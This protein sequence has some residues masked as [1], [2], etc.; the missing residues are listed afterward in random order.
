MFNDQ[1]LINHIKTTNTLQIESFILGEWNLNDFEN[2]LKYGNYRYRLSSSS[3]YSTLPNTYDEL[4]AGDYYTDALLSNIVTES[5]VDNIDEPIQVSTLE[6]NRDLYF[7]L[8]ECFQP[9]RPRSGI[10]KC[11]WFDNKYIDNIKSARR[12]RYYLSSRY[13]KFKYWNSYRKEDSQQFGIS[14]PTTNTDRGYSIEDAAPFIVYK[15]AVAANRIV[16]KM[17]TNLSELSGQQVRDNDGTVILDPLT[18]I[19]KSSIPKIWKVQ[20]LSNNDNWID[21]IA[22]DENSV[23][24][25]GSSIVNWDGHVELFYDIVVPEEYKD[26]FNFVSSVSASSQLPSP[27]ISGESYLVGGNTSN[28]GELYI[29]NNDKAEWDIS[30]PQ[31]GFSLLEDDDTKRLGIVSK[32]TDAEYFESNGIRTYRDVAYLK[33]LRVVVETM[34]SPNTTFDLIELSPRLKGNLSDY[35]LTYEINKKISKTST[36]MP[37]GG[38]SA[39]DGQ[40][41]LMNFD[42]SFNENNTNSLIYNQ[43]KPNVKIEF[44]EIVLNVEGYDKFIPIK[45]MYTEDFPIAVGGIFEVNIGLRDL[46]FKLETMNAPEILLNNT[47]LT[48]AVS[49]LLDNIGFSNYVFKNLT[50]DNDTIIPYFFIEPDTSVAEVLD[51]LAVATQTAMFFDEYNNFVVMSKEYLMPENYE[52]VEDYTLY[53]EKE[54]TTFANIINLQGLE[55][56][57]INSGQ[58]NYT[59]RY[60]QRSPSSLNQASKVDEDRTYV[61]KPVLLWEIGS[62]EE[63]KTINEKSKQVGYALG[64]VALNSTL[65]SEIPSVVNHKIINNIIDIGENVYWLPRFQGYLYA[66]GEVI[67]YDAVQYVIS[68]EAVPKEIGKYRQII[69]ENTITIV[70]I[71]KNN[72]TV[73]E[74]SGE[75]SKTLAL[76]KLRTLFDNSSTTTNSRDAVKNLV[77][78]TNNQEYQKYFANLPF[79]GKM[80]PTGSVRIY[81]EP[82]YEEVQ[83]SYA[84]GLEPNVILKNGP[85][86]SNGRGQFNTR[87]VQHSAGLSSYWSDNNNVRGLSMAS[88]YLFTTTPTERISFP[89][90]SNSSPTNQLPQTVPQQSLRTGI[91]ANFMRQNISVEDINKNFQTTS[92]GTIQ[93]SA[94]VFSGPNPLPAGSSNRDIVSYVYKELDKDYKHFGTRMRIIGKAESSEKILTA[95]NAFTYYSVDPQGQGDSPNISGGSGGIS[96]MVNPNTHEGYY[97]EI[98][99]LTGDNLQRYSLANEETGQATS[100]L[101]NIVFYKVQPGTVNNEVV[102]VPYKLWGGLAQIIVDEGKFVGQDRVSNQNN[103]T[104]Y[105]L[106][107]EYEDIG[108]IRRFYLY[109]N[110]SQVATVEDTSPLPAYSNIA[111]FTRGTSKCMFENVYALKNL[112][113]QETSKNIVDL[114]SK[115]FDNSITSSEAL[116]KYSMSG[117][118]QDTYLSGINIDSDKKFDIY[119]EEFGTIMRECAYFNIKYDKAYP[120][121]IAYI[122]PTFNKEKTYTVSGFRAGAYGAEFLIFNNTDKSIVLDETSGNYLRIIG[123]T[124]TQNTSNVLTVDDY[125]KQISNFFDPNIENNTL[126]SP[127]SADKVYKDIKMSRSRYGNKEF[128]LS[129]PYIQTDDFARNMMD[130]IIKKSLQPKKIIFMET[131][132]TSHLQ[133]GDIVKIRYNLPDGDIL[134]DPNKKFV[135]SEIFYS[136]SVSDVRNRIG[137]IEV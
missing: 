92:T 19:N 5:I 8:K 33:G 59:T 99:S 10:N 137:V 97:F 130:W 53:A 18:D 25:N 110:N 72:E 69:S 17:Q 128:S 108:S 133:L 111:L 106:A 107:V 42:G 40:L 85:V 82:Y 84:V 49:V 71:T 132:G 78:I 20:Y 50:T 90:K 24:R 21:A 100:V 63:S 52:R 43:L 119:F 105:D 118:I 62:Q 32:L 135:I 30:V 80:Y 73:A 77:W 46:F 122:A 76:N 134:I 44:Y 86:K 54:G 91:I 41:S 36:N 123:I 115:I 136:R 3:I 104:I 98:V 88:Q 113:T 120:A 68:G 34:Y 51:R 124:F 23:R 75:N 83:G 87:V 38:L 22:F 121:F 11:L 56:N 4:D 6:I 112:Q 55:K 26:S 103:P 66:N 13:D 39:S 57:V 114:S 65:T 102:L 101:H 31:Y 125:F 27:L 7:S 74:F 9:L 126:R 93:S 16:V 89:P 37:V 131:F 29:W 61:Y 96:V 109:V 67:R 70:D 58:I 95:Q 117:I 28:S 129:S 60:I 47:T 48:K 2:I 1:K 45:T 79:N 94:F 81:T 15:N 12:P 127:V 35:V 116:K 14:L 64:A